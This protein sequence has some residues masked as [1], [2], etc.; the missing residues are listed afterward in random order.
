MLDIRFRILE[1]PWPNDD[2]I[3]FSNPLPTAHFPRDARHPGFP[4]LTQDSDAATA[5]DLRSKG[6]HLVHFFVGHF[7]TDFGIG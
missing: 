3:A 6:E 5:E 1:I 2:Q 4:V 7:D